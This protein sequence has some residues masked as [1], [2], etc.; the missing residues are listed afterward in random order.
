MKTQLEFLEKIEQ[1]EI[2]P[3][4]FKKVI[5]KIEQIED[6]KRNQFKWLASAAV[7]TVL[8]NLGFVFQYYNSVNSNS[9]K[10][11]P[12]RYASSYHFSYE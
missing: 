2:P 8:F 10:I 12:Y 5:H 7:I 3:D 11:N 1:V 9:E 4:L 6:K